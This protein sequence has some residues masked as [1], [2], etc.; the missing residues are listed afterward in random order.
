MYPGSLFLHVFHL[1]LYWG[2]GRPLGRG[3]LDLPIHR[4]IGVTLSNSQLMASCYLISIVLFVCTLLLDWQPVDKGG[5]MPLMKYSDI[6][7]LY[8]CHL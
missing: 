7:Y 3:D 2:L 6:P 4:E 8:F 5:N 1:P